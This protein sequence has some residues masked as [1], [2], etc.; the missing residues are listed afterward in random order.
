MT[1]WTMALLLYAFVRHN[2]NNNFLM[3]SKAIIWTKENW[4]VAE[5]KLLN[6]LKLSNLGHVK[7]WAHFNNNHFFFC[8]LRCEEKM[9]GIRFMIRSLLYL[10]SF[11]A[12]MNEWKDYLNGIS[13]NLPLICTCRKMRM[14]SRKKYQF[15]TKIWNNEQ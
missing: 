11:I 1:V 7:S 9:N 6:A 13:W 8:F 5:E 15:I 2:H 14:L 4:D 10:T 12:I 3:L